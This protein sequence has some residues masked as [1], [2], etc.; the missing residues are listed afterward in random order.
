MDKKKLL[1]WILA[2]VGV[3]L[4]AYGGVRLTGYLTEMNRVRQT[5]AE[6][7][8]AAETAVPAETDV[9]AGTPAPMPETAAPPPA[10]T[11]V[12]EETTA[13]SAMLPD[14]AYPNGYNLVPKIQE[15]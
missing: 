12:P 14:V 3:L 11:A 15:L 10:E 13:V 4:V 2:V 7:R 5:T 6:L 9:P 1:R 8:E